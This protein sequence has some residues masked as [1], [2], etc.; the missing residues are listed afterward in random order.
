MTWQMGITCKIGGQA[1][2]CSESD[3]DPILRTAVGIKQR[4]FIFAAPLEVPV[5]IDFCCYISGNAHVY[6]IEMKTE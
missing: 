2:G 4:N 1:W 5:S 6:G 3:R